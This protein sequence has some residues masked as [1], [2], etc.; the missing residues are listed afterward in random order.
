M[1]PPPGSSNDLPPGYLPGDARHARRAAERRKGRLAVLVAAVVVVAAVAAT[2]VLTA[3]SNKKLTVADIEIGEC[4]VGGPN[5]LDTVACDEPHRYELFAVAEAPDPDAD[6]PGEE[7]ARLDG[8]NACVVALVGYY[9][10]PVEQAHADGLELQP[11]APT[12]EQW[13]A[14]E[15]DTYCLAVDAEGQA[16]DESIKGKGAG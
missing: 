12:E 1:P 4:F 2:V 15:T 16:L 5:D 7:T 8:G 11:V 6:F 10:A 9:G 3:N 14:G 13:N